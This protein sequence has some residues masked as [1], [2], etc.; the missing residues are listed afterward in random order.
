M[1]CKLCKQV[2]D[3]VNECPGPPC[4]V[5]GLPQTANPHPKAG[6]PE[7]LNVI[8]A[9][10]GCLPCAEKRANGRANVISAIRRWLETEAAV[11]DSTTI[12]IGAVL[13]KLN[14]LEENRRKAY[15]D[16]SAI[17]QSQGQGT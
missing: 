7:M 6:T 11:T 15:H 2:H 16:Q 14:Q 13:D 8:G 3:I 12:E 4:I 9:M 10:I 1:R 5:C 17:L